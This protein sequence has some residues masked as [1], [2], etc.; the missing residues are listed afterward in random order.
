MMTKAS[1][2]Y[3][4]FSSPTYDNDSNI[5]IQNNQPKNRTME[6]REIIPCSRYREM[7][8]NKRI[9]KNNP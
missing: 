2:S 9:E 1:Q 6:N 5:I 8:N 4:V 7:L 3:G